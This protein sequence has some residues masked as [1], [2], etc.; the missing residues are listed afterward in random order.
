M[1]AGVDARTFALVFRRDIFLFV[2]HIQLAAVSDIRTVP[3]NHNA[4]LNQRSIVVLEQAIQGWGEVREKNPIMNRLLHCTWEMKG[5]VSTPTA[6]DR[7]SCDCG[8]ALPLLP[9]ATPFMLAKPGIVA[10]L[11]VETTQK[12][13]IVTPRQQSSLVKMVQI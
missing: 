6:E 3:W 11:S 1:N 8:S 4:N 5:P 12:V 13:Q 7:K 2:S 9:T 10:K